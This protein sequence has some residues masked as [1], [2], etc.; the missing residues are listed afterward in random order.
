M[1]DSAFPTEK[2]PLFNPFLLIFLIVLILTVSL[3]AY[4]L[5]VISGSSIFGLGAK[6]ESFLIQ[7]Q[8]R[9]DYFSNKVLRILD[10]SAKGEVV[11]I[12]SGNQIQ[13]TLQSESSQLKLN[14]NPQIKVVKNEGGSSS[15]ISAGEIKIGDQIQAFLQLQEG[16]N[17][18]QT[19]GISVLE[20]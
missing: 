18:F 19:T 4:Y 14:L 20:K 11:K 17:R 13:I 7:E 16:G 8:L 12:T 5:L 10:M 15:N 1:Q 6:K 2:K 3:G 9:S